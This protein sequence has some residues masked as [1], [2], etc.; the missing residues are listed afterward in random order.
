MATLGSV[1][2]VAPT[3]ASARSP[4]RDQNGQHPSQD[5]DY[6]SDFSEGEED[7]V[8]GLLQHLNER[9]P[10]FATAATATTSTAV[11][12]TAAASTPVAPIS[13]PRN[14]SALGS[15]ENPTTGPDP[16]LPSPR[17]QQDPQH[18]GSAIPTAQATLPHQGFPSGAAK[19]PAPSPGTRPRDSDTYVSWPDP[20][21]R[22]VSYPDRE[23]PGG[24]YYPPKNG[25]CATSVD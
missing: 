6:G 23:F 20:S 25:Q 19:T 22:G 4:L 21:N 14:E 3:P 11:A 8:N 16:N 24:R 2:A 10:P 18:H 9:D 1:S 12:S 17:L 5:S 7:I 13:S 15:V